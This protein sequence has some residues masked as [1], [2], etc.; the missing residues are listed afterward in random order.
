MGSTRWLVFAL[1]ATVASRPPANQAAEQSADPTPPSRAG[2]ILAPIQLVEQF[3][4][5]DNPSA[6][7]KLIRRIDKAVGG[8]VQAVAEAL[9]KVSVWTDLD[10]RSAP[11]SFESANGSVAVAL[12]LPQAYVPATAYPVILSLPA[13]RVSAEETLALAIES[14]GA[15]TAGFVLV[16]PERLIGPAFHQSADRAG[17]IDRLLREVR[18][19]IHVD[20]DRVFLFGRAE[21]GEAAWMA[22]IMQPDLF[23]GAI[24]LDSFPRVAFPEQSY[25][26]L[27][28]NLHSVPVLTVWQSPGS[29]PVDRARQIVASHNRAIVELAQRMSLPIT[30]VEVSRDGSVGGITPPPASVSTLLANR[31]PPPSAVV[32]HWFRYPADGRTRWLV[33]TA[34][35]G[36]VWTAQQLAIAVTGTADRDEFIADTIKGKMAYLSGRIQ[37]QSVTIETLRCGRVDLLIPLG[38]MD[39]TKPIVVRCNG[40]KRRDGVVKP[41][42]RTLLETAYDRWEFQHPVAARVSFSIKTNAEQP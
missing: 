41:S 16:C 36:E 38:S 4:L 9:A 1:L 12:R 29:A 19:R 26:F 23:A 30:G 28:S 2:T 17:N 37:G 22:A 34:F 40:K 39:L 25:P 24:V 27:L 33:Q 8:D 42:V 5:S 6:R 7:T 13:A 11:F 14:L 10:G 3:L 35:L 21:G 32:S 20:T 31:R 15:A 18:R